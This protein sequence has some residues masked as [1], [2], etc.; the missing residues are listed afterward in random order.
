MF[1]AAAAEG[2]AINPGPEWTAD[3]AANKNRMRL[4]FGSASLDDIRAGV[5]KLAEV[6]HSEFGVPVRSANI[7]RD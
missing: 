6:C 2:V 4:C 1:Q 7:E 5:A 3:G